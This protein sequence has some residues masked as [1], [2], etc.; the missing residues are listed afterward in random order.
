[1][2]LDEFYR[3][4]DVHSST[5]FLSICTARGF[6]VLMDWIC[7][8]YIASVVTF[9]MLLQGDSVIAGYAGLAISSSL[10]LTGVTQWAVRCSADL[11]SYMTSVER[12]LEY[13]SLDVEDDA[14]A[15]TARH[16]PLRAPPKEK[17]PSSGEIIFERLNLWYDGAVKPVLVDI[18]CHIEGGSKVGVVGRT[19][20]GKSSLIAALFRLCRRQEGTISIDGMDTTKLT[21]AQLRRSISIIPQE[22]LIFTGSVRYNVDPFGE[23][24]DERLWEVLEEVQLKEVISHL[25]GLLDSHISEGGSNFSVGQRQLICLARAILRDNKVRCLFCKMNSH[26]LFF[27][28]S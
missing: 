19:G 1:M 15:L 21:L 13:T 26:Q 9:V 6:G 11:E 4:Q 25:P 17:W 23:H 5:N 28:R 2:F 18:S 10:V 14:R 22:P 3:H 20:A 16:Y 12:I 24:S 27:C 7:L 8:L